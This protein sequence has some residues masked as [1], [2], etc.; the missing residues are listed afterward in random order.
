MVDTVRLK[1]NAKR[2][3][4]LARQGQHNISAR[5]VVALVIHPLLEVLRNMEKTKGERW[6]TLREAA[7]RSGRGKNYF[8]KP[9][10]SRGGKCRL[11]LWHGEGLADKTEDGWWLISPLVVAEARKVCPKKADEQDL[12]SE[13]EDIAARFAA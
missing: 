12:A 11:E 8:E 3:A 6:L 4:W 2:V 13:V 7:R 10:V 9:L 1:K 5:L